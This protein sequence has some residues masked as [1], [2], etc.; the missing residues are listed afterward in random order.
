MYKLILLLTTK[1]LLI[2]LVFNI[3]NAYAQLNY[4]ELEATVPPQCFPIYINYY[5]CNQMGSEVRGPGIE[6]CKNIKESWFSSGCASQ[7]QAYQQ[8]QE[9][10]KAVE[11]NPCLSY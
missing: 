10:C 4:A 1:T 11:R 8:R 2:L 5:A 9:W 6:F 7:T 3:P